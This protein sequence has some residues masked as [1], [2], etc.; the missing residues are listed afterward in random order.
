MVPLKTHALPSW[1]LL[2]LIRAVAGV[3]ISPWLSS[4]PWNSCTCTSSRDSGRRL[5]RA[6]TVSLSGPSIDVVLVVEMDVVLD[7][8]DGRAV[9]GGVGLAPPAVQDGQV[10]AAVAA[11]L[12]AAGARGFQGAARVI[13][14]DVDALHQV[15]GHVDVVVLE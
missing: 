13:Q 8:A 6:W 9:V 4:T 3:G 11:H 1:A 10:D 5:T 2:W 15:A 14:Q 12:H 7:G